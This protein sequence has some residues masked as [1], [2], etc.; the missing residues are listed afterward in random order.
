MLK[1][2]LKSMGE[3]GSWPTGTCFRQMVAVASVLTSRY[4]HFR[5]VEEF[6]SSCE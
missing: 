3:E 2:V 5:H 1:Q 6:A 4:E